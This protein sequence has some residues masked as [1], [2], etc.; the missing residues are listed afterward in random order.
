MLDKSFNDGHISLFACNM[1]HFPTSIA[2]A[3]CSS[4]GT[5]VQEANNRSNILSIDSIC[6]TIV[7]RMQIHTMF[8]TFLSSTVRQSI[9]NACGWTALRAFL[10]PIFFPLVR[11]NQKFIRVFKVA[12]KKKVKV[13]CCN[14][15]LL[16]F[17]LPHHCVQGYIV[18]DL[19]LSS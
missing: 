16:F 2:L 10:F 13:H 11:P 3:L 9:P 7:N 18:H 1:Y 19:S 14:K 12:R 17:C 15:K 5:E 8:E 4:T 6:Q